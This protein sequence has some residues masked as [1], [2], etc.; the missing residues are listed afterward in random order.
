MHTYTKRSLSERERDKFAA[1]YYSVKTIAEA[2][3]PTMQP[4]SSSVVLTNF[5]C[6]RTF[7]GI[8]A[9]FLNFIRAQIQ[10]RFS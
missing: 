10:N 4:A 8:L 5:S 7:P 9:P 1:V 3:A 6:L 2:K